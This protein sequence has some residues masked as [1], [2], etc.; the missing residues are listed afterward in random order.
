MWSSDATL[1]G[2][3]ASNGVSMSACSVCAADS[4][5]CCAALSSA[6]IALR[7]RQIHPPMST[8]KATSPPTAHQS[9]SGSPGSTGGIL[10]GRVAPVGSFGATA[11]LGAGS[12][13]GGGG[14]AFTTGG[15]TTG[16]SILGGGGATAGG[17]TFGNSTFGGSTLGGS[18]LGAGGST[19]EARFRRA[20]TLAARAASEAGIESSF[21]CISATRDSSCF[22]LWRMES[23]AATWSSASSTSRR[24]RNCARMR[25]SIWRLR[26]RS[27][28]DEESLST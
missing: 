5:S 19:L 18:T 4:V 22:R 15:S 28:S 13:F 12:T 7:R 24:S 6:G 17:S 27:I 1:G 14:A 8:T 9:Q 20:S 21:N 25:S 3:G 16:G 23:I 10:M 26:D 11:T 2:S